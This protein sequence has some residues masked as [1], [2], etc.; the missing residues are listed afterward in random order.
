M[1]SRVASHTYWL[2]RYLERAE[3]MAR[4]MIVHDLMLMDLLD[5]DRSAIWNQ[6]VSINGNEELFSELYDTASEQNM[7][8]FLI[9]NPDNPC[10]LVSTLN[11][12]CY[13]LR[14]CRSVIP[15]SLYELINEI[16]LTAKVKSG[17][18]VVLTP[19]HGFLSQ[20]EH[21]LLAVAGAA[22][23]SMSYNKTFLFMRIGCFLERADMTSRILDVRSAKLLINSSTSV[24]SPYENTQWMA[25]LQSLQALDMFMSEV[26]RPINGPD[27]LNFVLK[28]REHPK[29]FR[30]CIQRLDNFLKR[31]PNAPELTEKVKNM[32]GMVDQAD[33]FELATNQVELHDFIDRL[34]I[35]LGEIA[36]EINDNY[37]PIQNQSQTQE[38]IQ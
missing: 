28:N 19:S 4:T 21:N 24:L 7:L 31:L 12:V 1:L 3:D 11:A 6:L 33:V 13:N 38:Q 34:Q 27:V 23:G 9:T 36:V 16:C 8:Q 17:N 25:I 15:K 29:S 10:S 5:V 26:R 35:S 18:A 22:N 32:L 37:F 20:V 30:F 14:A 2:G